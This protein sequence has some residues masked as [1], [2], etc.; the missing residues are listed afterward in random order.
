MPDP[1]TGPA[2]SPDNDDWEQHNGEFLAAALRWLRL[3]LIQSTTDEELAGAAAEV[4]RTERLGPPAL[5]GLADR[6]GLSRFERDTLLLAVAVELDPGIAGLCAAANG[7]ERLAHPTFGLALRVLPDPAW[8]VLSP[9][10]GLRFWQLVELNQLPGQPLVAAAIRADERIVHF[11][12]GLNYLDDRLDHLVTPLPADP[13]LDLPDSQREVI[14]ALHA[15]WGHPVQLAGADQASKRLI[16][17]RAAA[18]AGLLAYRLP[19]NL[20]PARPAE[21]DALTRLWRRESALLPVALYLDA[22][23]AD[24]TV[25][26]N[27]PPVGRFID[28]ISGPVLFAARESWPDLGRAPVFDVEPPTPAERADAWQAQLGVPGD[29]L[30]GQFALDV[31]TIRDIAVP[32]DPDASWQAAR[33]HT[34]PRLD[35]LAQRLVPKIGLD[36]IVLPDDAMAVLNQITEQ[37]EHRTTVYEQWGFGARITRG[38]GVSALFAGPSGTGK[39]MAAEV[40]A[41]QLRLDLYRIDLSAVVSKYIGETE[42]NLRRVF[43]AAEGGGAVLFFDECDALFG[44]RSEVKDAHDRYANIQVNYLL[45]RIEAY[46]GLAILA[47]NTRTALDHAFLRRLRFV[48]EFPFPAHEQRKAI[49]RKAFPAGA[50]LAE[51][52]FDRLAALPVSGGVARNVALNAAF[53]AAA[54]GGRIDMRHLL[55]AARAEFRKLELPIRERD[56]VLGGEHTG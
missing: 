23:D 45:Q 19:V 1:T 51:L 12:K 2:D 3:R 47:T 4:T 50:P 33:A 40:L 15:N 41:G 35:S 9:R 6:L 32:G 38:L 16:A 10:R 18:E 54:D 29:A 37:V 31:G 25:E 24:G 39:T 56:F 17:A 48:V 46:R 43:D 8:E 42:K 20:L 36:D 53:Q 52:D 34:R 55:A 22:E 13:G 26:E 27:R 49:W 11:V 44:K 7:D 30:A 14:E 5:V 21:L 28:R